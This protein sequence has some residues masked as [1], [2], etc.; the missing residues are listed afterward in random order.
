V[1][2]YIGFDLNLKPLT[3]SAGG[4]TYIFPERESL[5]TSEVFGKVELNDAL[6]FHSDR[7]FLSPYVYGAYDV[8]KYDGLYMEAGLKHDLPIPDFG[9][10]LSVVADVGYV[11]NNGQFSL[12]NGK[13][14]GFQHYDIGL[15][16]NYALNPAFNIP[17]RFGEWKLIGYLYYT[18][19]INKDLRA[20]TQIWGGM[21]I[22]FEY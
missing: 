3:V 16:G 17:R 8:D 2:P 4:I 21:G 20:D 22:R 12:R 1:R 6:L 10:V 7:P 5:N 11:M 15:I 9:V 13:D 18:D 14:T 19:S